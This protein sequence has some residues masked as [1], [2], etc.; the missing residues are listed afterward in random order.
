M[1]QVNADETLLS[2]DERRKKYVAKGISVQNPICTVRAEGAKMWDDQGNEYIDFAGGI[3]CLNVGSAN[4][5]VVQVVQEQA[6]K[7][8]HTCVHVTL[9]EPYIQLAEELC[10][11]TPIEG[12]KKAFL[13]NSGAEAVENAVKIARSYTGRK[14]V[15]AFE[16]AFHGRTMLGMTLTS[17]VHPYKAGFGPFVPEVYRVPYAYCYRCP[18]GQTEGTCALECASALEQ[19]FATYVDANDVAAV[20]LEPVQGEGGFIVPPPA[21]LPRVREICRERGIL[22]IMDEVQ[23]GFGRTGAM[24]STNHY[25]NLDPDVMIMAK[26]MGAGLPISGVVGRA[27]IMDSTEVGGL[28]GT[29]GGNPLAA[30]AALKVIEI[31]ERDQLPKRAQVIGEKSVAAL[32]KL[33][34]KFPMIG[35]IR[36]QGAMVAFELVKDTVSKEPYGEACARI[37]KKCLEKG[38]ITVKAGVF[39]NVIRLLAPLVITDEE[40]ERGLATI[41]EAVVE[42]ATELGA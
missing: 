18:F 20:I 8:L 6:A 26:S 21:Y 9:N 39:N 11:I 33:Q 30:V 24:F 14:A 42:T 35:D 10:R 41:A 5:E 17:K 36:A 1:A 31:M 27:E 2:I 4:P 3:G 19:A 13:A 7:F 32:R 12:E 37:S 40:L 25:E 28:G 22:F 29:F 23:S 15:L 38:L 16:Y 34:E